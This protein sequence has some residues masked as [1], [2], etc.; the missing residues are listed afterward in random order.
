MCYAVVSLVK[1]FTKKRLG[2]AYRFMLLLDLLHVALA[3]EPRYGDEP[4]GYMK[5]MTIC[6][7]ESTYVNTSVN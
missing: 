2:R 3:V 6:A 7:A 1:I 4:D 5:A